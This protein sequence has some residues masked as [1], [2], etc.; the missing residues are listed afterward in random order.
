MSTIEVNK[1]TPVS[2]G[3]AIQV[4]ESGDTI[5]IP[6]GATIANAGT[7]TGFGVSLANGADNRVVTASSASALNGEANLTFDGTNLTLG[8][9]NIIFG[10]ASKGVYLGVTSA[11]A[12]NLLDDYENGTWTP[13]WSFGT[14][15]SSNTANTSGYWF[16]VGGFVTVY[17]YIAQG[18]T[19]SSP[20][21]TTY[22]SSLPFTPSGGYGQS[23]N[24]HGQGW[25]SGSFG[26]GDSSS[27]GYHP[28]G[29]N[30]R[31]NG[32]ELQSSGVSPNSDARG[33]RSF[34]IDGQTQSFNT[35]SNYGQCYFGAVYKT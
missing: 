13:T 24:F 6:A 35:N 17:G 14:S 11:T 31:T 7:A 15:G 2:G 1:I 33:G 9:G 18:G 29:L 25:V 22:I 3:T 10:T 28:T 21:G 5:N 19:I 30:V 26:W 8:T 23:S 16:K 34:T 27:N 20:T 12:S 4:G 32:L